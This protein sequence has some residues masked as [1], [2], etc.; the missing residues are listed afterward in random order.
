MITGCCLFLAGS[1]KLRQVSAAGA[2]WLI[3]TRVISSHMEPRTPAEIIA[4]Q[5]RRT[6]FLV[7]SDD[8]PVP[9][10]G[11]HAGFKGLEYFPIDTKYQL[12]L[13]LHKYENP[14]RVPI[15]L[16]NGAKVEALRV[17]YLRFNLDGKTLTLNVYKKREDD[18]EVFLPFRDKTSG[19]ETYGAGR[20][21]DLEVDPSDNSCV[22]DFNLSYNPLCAFGAGNFDCPIPPSENWLLDVEIRAGE[23]KF[24][25]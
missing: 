11:R 5:K 22:L 7:G 19:H 25:G 15:S 24:L 2:L 8:S 6:E 9:I 12:K 14:G 3:S 17:G 16:S 23:M 10:G 20:Y 1:R 4:I 13:K 18:T 21:V